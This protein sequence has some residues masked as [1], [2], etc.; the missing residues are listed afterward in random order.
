[1]FKYFSFTDYSLMN[2]LNN[3]FYMNHYE[4]FN[5]P[6]ECRSEIYTGF[7]DKTSNSPRVNEI[8]KA[9]GFD[10]AL[11]SNA[12]EY[13]EDLVLSLEDTEPSVPL[14][15]DRARISCFSKSPNNLLMWAHYANGLRG[16]CIE[17]DR[18]KLLT[19]E[20][21]AEI[22]DVL[23]ANKPPIIDTAVVA[24]LND[25]VNY[26]EDTIY[27]IEGRLK[28]TTLNRNQ[29]HNAHSEIRMYKEYL[30]TVYLKNREI[31]QKM[32]ATKSIEWQY[33]EE[34]RLIMQTSCIDKSGV[35]LKYPI[36]SLKCIIIGEKMP[37]SQREALM[38][39]VHLKSKTIKF[40]IARRIL[41]QFEVIIDDLIE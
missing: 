34:L 28:F 35:N 7:P 10:D 37:N 20:V 41:G 11:D 18:D 30:D 24:V 12:L 26:H 32:L 36:Q 25:Q 2:L 21:N 17:Y 4:S 9:W 3:Q 5:D 19:N 27:E 16:F 23:Y 14:T 6:F 38:N 13:Y 31:Y 33:E 8:I 15:I 29:K 22:F 40:K 39:I 1:M